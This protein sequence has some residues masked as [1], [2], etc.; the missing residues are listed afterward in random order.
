MRRF[1]N[2][3]F[4][5]VVSKSGLNDVVNSLKENQEVAVDIEADSMFHFKEKVCLIQLATEQHL[6]IVDTI[7]IRD[8]SS[9]KPFFNNR[10][11][12]KV[13]HGADYDVRSL[14]RDFD[15]VI[16]NLFD[17]ELAV[18]FLGAQ[19]SGLNTV[20]KTYFDINLQKKF[21]KKDW[22]QRPLPQEMIAYAAEDVHYLLPLANLIQSR[23]HQKNRLPWVIE[24]CELLSKVRPNSNNTKPLYLSFKGAGRLAP[25][26]LAVLDSILK[27]RILTAQKKDFP[28]FKIIGNRSIIDLVKAKPRTMDALK[29]SRAISS[30]QVIMYGRQLLMAVEDGLDQPDDQLPVYPRSRAPRLN[31]STTKLVKRLKNWK[32]NKAAELGIDASLVLSKSQAMDIANRAPVSIKQLL[33]IP[34]LKNWQIKEF[35]KEILSCLIF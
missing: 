13:F 27:W 26:D 19:Q 6:F 33:N 5:S 21:Q 8:L 22:S 34:S 28:P 4:E 17:T 30:K 12:K 23:L 25:R 7:K 35:G 10:S 14:Y 20:L 15:I 18:R 31:L 24:E 29:E 2:L 32:E 3:K 16:N 1:P 11:I 9:L